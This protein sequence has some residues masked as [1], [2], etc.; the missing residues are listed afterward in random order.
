MAQKSYEELKQDF[1]KIQ[2]EI[3]ALENEVENNDE[4]KELFEARPFFTTFNGEKAQVKGDI[5]EYHYNSFHYALS[6][7]CAQIDSFFALFDWI[8][9]KMEEGAEK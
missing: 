3:R 9:K 4:I 6:H 5:N 2:K 1:F 7:V 8:K